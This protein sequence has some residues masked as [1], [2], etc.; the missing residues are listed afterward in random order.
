MTLR[1]KLTVFWLLLVMF[2]FGP[3]AIGVIGVGLGKL[4]LG[5][6][7]EVW[8]GLEWA[9]VLLFFTVPIG[10]VLAVIGALAS[11]VL[12]NRASRIEVSAS[13]KSEAS[14]GGRGQRLPS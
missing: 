11:A 6:K 14:D 3:L 5:I 8:R 13:D 9:P 7:E 2:S 12:A 4:G 10:A 1:T